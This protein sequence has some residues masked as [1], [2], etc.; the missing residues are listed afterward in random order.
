[1]GIIGGNHK[2]H[3]SAFDTHDAFV[4]QSGGNVFIGGEPNKGHQGW[5][6][7]KEGDEP[8]FRYDPSKETLYMQIERGGNLCGSYSVRT[9]P[10]P[11][12][13]FRVLANFRC[14]GYCKVEL[15]TATDLE[16]QD[17]ASKPGPID[18]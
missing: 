4:W 8:L 9:G 18:F 13:G 17:T 6:G 2:P 10:C 3:N 11:P 16:W 5:T 12:E 14:F 15:L 1:M 7:F